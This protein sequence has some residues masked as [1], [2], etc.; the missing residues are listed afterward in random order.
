M[1]HD[2]LLRSLKQHE[3]LRLKAYQDTENVWTCGYGKNLQELEITEK[4]AEV[5]LID[6]VYTAIR[7]LDRAFK[8]WRDHSEARQNVL[9]EMMFQMGATRLA[10]F[11]KFWQAMRLQ[12]YATAAL[13]MR[14]SRWASQTPKRVHALATRMEEDTFA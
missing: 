7:E 5:W 3:G 8:G 14:A 13:E 4:Q 9:I 11:I 6:D 2:F 12:D 1:N 10:G